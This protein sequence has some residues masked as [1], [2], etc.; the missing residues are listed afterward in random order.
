[1]VKVKLKKDKIVAHLAKKNLSQNWL[2]NKLEMSS[3][4][5]SQLLNGKRMPSPEM[6]KRFLN[7]F[8]HLTFDE[9]F[10]ILE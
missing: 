8:E 3:A 4:Y 7:Y 9:L 6:R 1:M 5:I 2:A 10:E